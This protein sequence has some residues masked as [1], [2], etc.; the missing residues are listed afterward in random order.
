M[1]IVSLLTFVSI[2][3]SFFIVHLKKEYVVIHVRISRLFIVVLLR[4]CS[5]ETQLSQIVH[6]VEVATTQK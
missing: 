3:L 2:D 4:G 5:W 6:L 1:L